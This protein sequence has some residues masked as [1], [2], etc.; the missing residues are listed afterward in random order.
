MKYLLM[1]FIYMGQYTQTE[2]RF[3]FFDPCSN[4]VLELDYQ[5]RKSISDTIIEV[6][7][8]QSVNLEEDNYYQ[9]STQLKSE[10][11]DW[12]ATFNFDIYNMQS[13]GV[14]TLYLH[15]LRSMWNGLLHPQKVAYYFCN[16]ICDG[17]I[18]EVD[19]NGIIRA[20]GKFKKGVPIS[21]IRFFDKRGNVES[22]WI[23][24]N[25]NLIKIR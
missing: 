23:Y 6:K 9:V 20:K 1:L 25:G 8:G 15:Q 17:V 13:T 11:N 18:E 22:K 12:I 2:Q 3:V 4:R 5:I 19:S 24:R 21:N 7:A 14:D 16:S 10:H